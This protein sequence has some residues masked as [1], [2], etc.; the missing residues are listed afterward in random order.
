MGPWSFIPLAVFYLVFAAFWVKKPSSVPSKSNIV[1]PIIGPT[2]FGSQW[3]FTGPNSLAW[4]YGKS[5]LQTSKSKKNLLTF[6][7]VS[8]KDS[9][10]IILNSK[11]DI[12]KLAPTGS[13]YLYL[14]GPQNTSVKWTT[15][16]RETS[17]VSGQLGPIMTY[18]EFQQSLDPVNYTI[19]PLSSLISFVTIE[20]FSSGRSVITMWSDEYSRPTFGKYIVQTFLDASEA[21][22]LNITPLNN[23]FKVWNNNDDGSNELIIT[24][25]LRN[26]VT[27]TSFIDLLNN[28]LSTFDCT[29]PTLTTSPLRVSIGSLE[30]NFLIL[31]WTSTAL[32]GQNIRI[33]PN[34]SLPLLNQCA[35]AA[36]LGIYLINSNQSITSNL[37][38]QGNGTSFSVMSPQPVVL[39]WPITQNYKKLDNPGSSDID[40]L[41]NVYFTDTAP[42][43]LTLTDVPDIVLEASRFSYRYMF[44]ESTIKQSAFIVVNGITNQIVIDVTTYA[45]SDTSQY[46]KSFQFEESSIAG[47]FSPSDTI[48]LGLSLNGSSKKVFVN[49]TYSNI[50]DSGIITFTHASPTTFGLVSGSILNDIEINFSLH[51]NHSGLQNSLLLD[52]SEYNGNFN[53]IVKPFGTFLTRYSET[54]LQQPEPSKQYITFQAWAGGGGSILEGPFFGGSTSRYQVTIDRTNMP[55]SLIDVTVGLCGKRNDDFFADGGSHSLIKYNNVLLCVLGGGGGAA[56]GSNGGVGGGPLGPRYETGSNPSP[57]S[58]DYAYFPGYSGS[59]GYFS[60][61]DNPQVEGPDG[62]PTTT[63]PSINVETWQGSGASDISG[64]AGYFLDANGN[65]IQ[66]QKSASGGSGSELISGQISF[67]GH[68]AQFATFYGAGGGGS[69]IALATSSILSIVNFQLNGPWTADF[70]VFS[71]KRPVGGS[72]VPYGVSPNGF[73][74]NPY[75]V[76]GT[77]LITELGTI[78]N[79]TKTQTWIKSLLDSI[80]Q[81]LFKNPK[82][83]D[84]KYTFGQAYPI[85]PQQSY[86]AIGQTDAFLPS[87]GGPNCTL[88]DSGETILFDND[89]TVCIFNDG[90]I[91][92]F[93]DLQFYLGTDFLGPQDFQTSVVSIRIGPSEPK[94]TYASCIYLTLADPIT[95]DGPFTWHL[96]NSSGFQQEPSVFSKGTQ[97]QSEGILPNDS[98]WDRTFNLPGTYPGISIANEFEILSDSLYKLLPN[99]YIGP[100]FNNYLFNTNPILPNTDGVAFI[101]ASDYA[102]VIWPSLLQQ[103]SGSQEVLATNSLLKL[104]VFIR[105]IS[106]PNILRPFQTVIQLNFGED[107]KIVVPIGANT[108]IYCFGAGGSSLSTSTKG[109]DGS[110]AK[111]TSSELGGEIL[112]C[113]IGQGGGTGLPQGLYGGL[114]NDNVLGGGC[115][116]VSFSDEYF[117]EVSNPVS[118]AHTQNPVLLYT[119]IMPKTVYTNIIL[120]CNFRC[121]PSTSRL[122]DIFHFYIKR[123][124]GTIIA[125]F[126]DRQNYRTVNFVPEY[127][128]SINNFKYQSN[129]PIEFW[130]QAAYLHTLAN[131]IS[132]SLKIETET[133]FL[134]VAGGGGAGGLLASA[135]RLP[136]LTFAP[137][138]P[139]I[140]K[141]KSS[142]SLSL[143]E[144]NGPGGSGYYWGQSGN[145]YGSAGS[146]GSSFAPQGFI[147]APQNQKYF[148][149]E[150]SLGSSTVAGNGRIVIEFTY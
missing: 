94:K 120:K 51:K 61:T 131:N 119:F 140:N 30:G 105:P 150:I 10:I 115:S 86:L 135:K 76:N 100:L 49:D 31:Q 7:S 88:V 68:G 123:S 27:A 149:P 42:D 113:R 19:I 148:S 85:T 137:G 55:T 127:E 78:W 54:G 91:N 146:S 108:T 102:R 128:L 18:K 6:Q 130:F 87:T 74:L 24:L 16:N 11:S 136:E 97:Y 3:P 67:G 58:G 33:G 90:Q 14:L 63:S 95:S 138:L 37:L 15:A 84:A 98:Q 77:N 96:K 4:L 80:G 46:I 75:F 92:N 143:F 145:A 28:E 48:S 107:T 45:V 20:N 142:T 64:Q 81:Q 122:T 32:S 1:F 34:P 17:Q 103:L 70:D 26:N 118:Q 62:K 109:A 125:E 50:L 9:F 21:F 121:S 116:I 2:P 8:A 72:N 69:T 83:V 133:N 35:A 99:F 56:M 141:I 71:V 132:V 79:R 23:S 66:S 93:N 114:H 117:N 44:P 5:Q 53:L 60:I 40:G 36:T 25:P 22:N 89:Y 12:V 43:M 106:I 59:S 104:R 39:Q 29:T 139:E 111:M 124:N 82:V 144:S 38:I 112:T 41:V 147:G 101:N 129:E 110:F 13:G 73:S 126:S 57:L 134:V 52:S 65:E 47:I